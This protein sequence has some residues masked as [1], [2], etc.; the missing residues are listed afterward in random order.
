MGVQE[1]RLR[2]G[3]QAQSLDPTLFALG[4]APSIAGARMGGPTATTTTQP[5][6]S[7]AQGLSGGLQS[8]GSSLGNF[9][10]LSTLLGQSNAPATS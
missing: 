5:N 3:Q 8:A 7:A 2:V 10:L 9:A 4:A 6:T 1:G